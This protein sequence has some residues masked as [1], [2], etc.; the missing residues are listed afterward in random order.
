M[1]ESEREE[2]RI[3]L[4]SPERGR[5]ESLPCLEVAIRESLERHFDPCGATCSGR[6]E[7]PLLTARGDFS[8]TSAVRETIGLGEGCAPASVP[9][10]QR[11]QG[12]APGAR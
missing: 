12:P 11:L 4:V 6:P 1:R 10:V 5:S 9:Q 3:G 2:D 7:E 8:D